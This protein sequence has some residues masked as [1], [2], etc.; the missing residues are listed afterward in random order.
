MGPTD[1]IVDGDV[2]KLGGPF[3]QAWQKKYLKLY[4]NRLEFY[5]KNKDELVVKSKGVE[6]SMNL[7]DC[8]IFPS[9]IFATIAYVICLFLLSQVCPLVSIAADTAH[10][11]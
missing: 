2:L 4:P 10:R 8:Y 1:C 11:C 3:N 5:H 9:Y 7:N 6:V